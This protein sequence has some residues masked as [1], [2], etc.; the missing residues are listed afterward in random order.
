MQ[1]WKI[2]IHCGKI[3]CLP[4]LNKHPKNSNLHY[5]KITGMLMNRLKTIWKNSLLIIKKIP[6]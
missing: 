6:Q 1:I 4:N 2:I 3:T 5:G